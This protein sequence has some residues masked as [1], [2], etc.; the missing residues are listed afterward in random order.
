MAS[1]PSSIADNQKTSNLSQSAPKNIRYPLLSSPDPP[2]EPFT[3]R[4]ASTIERSTASPMASTSAADAVE[5]S[6]SAN[7]TETSSESSGEQ[8]RTLTN[9]ESMISLDY[10]TTASASPLQSKN[11]SVPNLAS[12]NAISVTG[13]LADEQYSVPNGH[14]RQRRGSQTAFATVATSPVNIVSNPA[15]A[16][17]MTHDGM[18]VQVQAEQQS[19]S[20]SS[21]C[22][23]SAM[24]RPESTQSIAAS[25]TSISPPPTQSAPPAPSGASVKR[26][27]VSSAVTASSEAAEKERER[28]AKIIGRIGVCALD[29]K[30]RSKPCRVILNRLIE[31][32]EFETVIFGDKV[33]LDEG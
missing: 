23:Q 10:P 18:G 22:F 17:T 8:H 7:H 15:T 31:N 24:A 20:Q 11:S 4:R 16:R 27:S 28:K 5:K 32:G 29:A 33:I 1:H 13:S 19:P 14:V 2:F 6:I 25:K 26:M 12:G 30:A 9:R 3:K 21:T